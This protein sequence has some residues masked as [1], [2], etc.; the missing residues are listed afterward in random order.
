[1]CAVF[2]P[3]ILRCCQ[4]V[5]PPLWGDG[6]SP[7]VR[8][9]SICF[10][11]VSHV[12]GHHNRDPSLV[13]EFISCRFVSY[14]GM[15]GLV[16]GY[17][18][19]VKQYH[20]DSVPFPPPTPPTLRVKVSCHCQNG[21]PLQFSLFFQHIPLAIAIIFPILSLCQVLSYATTWLVLN[22]LFSSWVY[23]RFFQKNQQGSRGDMSEG[24]SFATFFPEPIQS[25]QSYQTH[26]LPS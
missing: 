6:V 16:C 4:C 26:V 3:A 2:I 15:I 1:M 8:C 24:F 22:G 14:H 19:A 25:V 18:V 23:L 13:W 12:T 11:F 7:T 10:F 5:Q 9:V 20:P 21:H 17:V